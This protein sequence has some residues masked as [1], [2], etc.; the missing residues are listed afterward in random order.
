MASTTGTP[1][2]RGD[3]VEVPDA[4]A[5]VQ[6]EP[7]VEVGA[8]AQPQDRRVTAAVM[9]T[10]HAPPRT[11][12][13]RRRRVAA[14]QRRSAPA[15]P[16]RDVP[17]RRRAVDGMARPRYCGIGHVP[18]F[19]GEMRCGRRSRLVARDGAVILDDTPDRLGSLTEPAAAAL[20]DLVARERRHGP[21]HA[22]HTLWRDD[23]TEIADR[24]GWL[25]V[26]ADMSAG[27]ESTAARCTALAAGSTTV[28]RDGRL[29]PVPRARRPQRRHRSRGTGAARARHDRSGGHRLASAELPADRTLHVAAPKSGS[30]LETRSHPAGPGAATLTP[31]GSR[32]SPTRERPRRWRLDQASPR[33]SRTPPDIGGRY[34]ALSYFGLVPALLGQADVAGLLASAAGMSDRLRASAAANLAAR[35]AAAMAAGVR[36]GR[37]SVTIVPEVR[38]TFGLWLEQLLAESTG[39]DGMGVVP[40]VGEPLAGPEAYGPDRLFVALGDDTAATELSALA[41]AGHPVVAPVRRRVRGPGG[42]GAAGDGHRAGGRCSASSRSISPTSRPPRRRRPRCWRRV[43][44]RSRRRRSATSSA[45]SAPATTSPSRRSST[46]ARPRSTRSSGRG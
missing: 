15:G 13:R 11:V 7:D 44:R 34:S 3:V 12:A 37:D 31:P 4:G 24:L 30:T 25:S 18:Y 35:L 32:P 40:V 10:S 17:A 1:V 27:L 14:P 33:P 39:K 43:H 28:G 20:A 6:H 22:H 21:G 46:L 38:A 8:V 26:V 16:R 19:G 29:E 23:L 36:N 9:A 41:D 2:A 5:G 45:R 42:A